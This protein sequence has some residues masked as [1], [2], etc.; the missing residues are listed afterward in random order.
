MLFSF[1]Q[2]KQQANTTRKDNKKLKRHKNKQNK[3]FLLFFAAFGGSHCQRR[4]FRFLKKS[5]FQN[6]DFWIDI[7]KS[8][9]T[10]FLV[11]LSTIKCIQFVCT[12]KYIYIFCTYCIVIAVYLTAMSV[13]YCMI[14]K[15]TLNLLGTVQ[16]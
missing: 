2:Q 14:K 7:Q 6:H 12:K 13:Q 8:I 5:D 16:Y 15:I 10:Y 9:C 3:P 1:V 4:F 11:L